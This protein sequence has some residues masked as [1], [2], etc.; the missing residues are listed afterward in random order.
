[1]ETVKDVDNEFDETLVALFW[2][3]V[4]GLSGHFKLREA[5]DKLVD[6][7]LEDIWVVGKLSVQ[8]DQPVDELVCVNLQLHV[9]HLG[10]VLLIGAHHSVRHSVDGFTHCLDELFRSSLVLLEK[11]FVEPQL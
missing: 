6:S 4:L 2:F 9:D 7:V 3:L 5:R 8:L 1:M 11:W 10:R